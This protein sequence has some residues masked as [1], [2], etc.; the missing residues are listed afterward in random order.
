MIGRGGEEDIIIMEVSHTVITRLSKAQSCYWYC[1]RELTE[2]ETEQPTE[3]ERPDHQNCLSVSYYYL[4]LLELL[5]VG[6]ERQI[7]V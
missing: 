5:R 3:S 6:N 4:L 7:F 1:G 2:P